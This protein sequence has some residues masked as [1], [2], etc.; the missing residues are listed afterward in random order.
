VS[1][2]RDAAAQAPEQGWWVEATDGL[3]SERAVLFAASQPAPLAVV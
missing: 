1:S 2:A 3:C